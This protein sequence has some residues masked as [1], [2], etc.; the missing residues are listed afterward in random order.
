[1][2]IKDKKWVYYLLACIIP[3]IVVCIAMFIKGIFPFGDKTVFLWD[4][5]R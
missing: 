2:K 3:T 1:M 5:Y 4:L